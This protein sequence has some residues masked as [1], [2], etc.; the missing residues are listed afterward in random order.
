[1]NT[2]KI[3]HVLNRTGAIV[4]AHL[5]IDIIASGSSGNSVYLEPLHLLIDLGIAFKHYPK[6][7]FNKVDYI[8]LTHEHGDHLNVTCLIKV[9]EEYPHIKFLLTKDLAKCLIS[10]DFE[11]MNA[12]RDRLL[13]VIREDSGRFQTLVPLSVE[14]RSGLT[15]TIDP[16]YVTH[17]DINNVGFDIQCP[18][19]SLKMLYATD[20]DNVNLLPKKDF[21]LIMLESNFDEEMLLSVLRDDPHDV[22]ANNNLRHIS[23]QEAFRYVQR[24]LMNEGFI[25]RFT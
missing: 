10:T 16:I 15:Y 8:A 20:L 9:L 11:R 7:F 19:M 2:N 12:K 18:Q 21:N 4:Q 13:K 24:N 3:I 17:G 22:R 1:M 23:E 25:Y 14:T 6:G 5:P